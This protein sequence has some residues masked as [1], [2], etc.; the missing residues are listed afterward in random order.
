MLVELAR[1]TDMFSSN[2]EADQ[3]PGTTGQWTQADV[4]RRSEEAQRNE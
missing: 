1:A 4:R 2:G 3:P